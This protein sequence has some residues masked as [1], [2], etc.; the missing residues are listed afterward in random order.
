LGL[1]WAGVDLDQ[2][3]L[4]VQRTLQRVDGALRFVPPKTH[5][6]ARPVPL[7]ALAVRALRTQRARQAE[8]RLAAGE[9]WEVNDLVFASTIGTPMEPRNVNRRFYELRR[10]A[11]LEWLRLHDL[12]HAFATFL[13]DQGEELRTVM[14]LLGH[15]TIRLTADTYGHVLPA[16]ARKATEAIDNIL[17]GPS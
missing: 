1:R 13:L 9:L 10:R 3:V 16:R 17:G 12:R 5:R 15:S 11:G 14:E 6:S 7:S 2:A 4:T 8:E